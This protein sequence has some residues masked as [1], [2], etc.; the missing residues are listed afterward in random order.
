VRLSNVD[1]RR[2]KGLKYKLIGHFK[3][4]ADMIRGGIREFVN[5]MDGPAFLERELMRL[6]VDGYW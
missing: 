2:L 1:T 5:D 3:L 4:A 6:G